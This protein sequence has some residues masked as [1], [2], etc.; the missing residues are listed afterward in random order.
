MLRLH[1]PL[2]RHCDNIQ[3]HLGAL[4]FATTM[5]CVTAIQVFFFIELATRCQRCEGHRERYAKQPL[6]SALFTKLQFCGRCG[7]PA[8]RR[9]CSHFLSLI[10]GLEPYACHGW[11]PL[12]P[13]DLGLPRDYNDSVAKRQ[14]T[15]LKQSSGRRCRIQGLIICLVMGSRLSLPSGPV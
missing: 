14:A 9:P 1:Q 6:V 3:K 8:H 10:A 11:T 2:S 15:L 5:A 7:P 12:P 4:F 13:P